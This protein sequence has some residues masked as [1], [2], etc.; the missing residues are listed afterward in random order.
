MPLHQSVQSLLLVGV[1]PHAGPAPDHVAPPAPLQ[2]LIDALQ[3]ELDACNARALEYGHRYRSAFWALYLLSALAVLFAVMPDAL[4]WTEEQH[5]L[6]RFAPLWGAGEL[7]IV[8]VVVGTYVWG[9]RHDWQGEWLGARMQA[10]LTGYLPLAATLQ[11][12]GEETAAFSAHWF[13]SVAGGSEDSAEIDR[14]EALCREHAPLGLHALPLVQQ[15]VAGWAGWMRGVVAGQQHYHERVAHRQHA[16]Q[17][18][19]HRINAV[20]FG[21]TA[22][23][24]AVH[25]VWH[26]S[27][28]LLAATVFPALGAA[29]HGALAQSEAYRLELSSRRLAA[30]LQALRSAIEV[31]DCATPVAA[32][33]RLRA[34]GKKALDVILAE[35]HD[36]HQLVRPHRLP[37]G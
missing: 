23:G 5:P 2:P 36:W 1:R 33:Q 26:A 7:A 20:L 17:H 18:R 34:L 32:R 22:L 37:L 21:L 19:I 24:T 8:V 10:E 3:P 13:A 29:L 25:L 9:H 27:G 6:H 4:G 15:D 12:P 31:G 35:H 30:E 14:V 16:L 28:L 11:E